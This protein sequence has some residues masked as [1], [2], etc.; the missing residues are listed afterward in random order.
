MTREMTRQQF[1]A[2]LERNGFKKPVLL[3]VESRDLP[4]IHFSMLLHNNG[5]VARRATIAHLIKS[6]DAELNKLKLKA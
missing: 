2:A 4:G 5:K 1:H 3:W 6:R